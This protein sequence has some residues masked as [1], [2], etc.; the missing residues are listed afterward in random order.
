MNR[1]SNRLEHLFTRQIDGEATGEEREFLNTLLRDDRTARTLFRE[2]R[3]QDRALGDALRQALGRPARP[4]STHY[5]RLRIGRGLAA[6][7]A[8]G[9]A[10][11]IWLQPGQ[12]N[13]NH[14]KQGPLQAA[15]LSQAP[16]GSWFTPL[17][18]AGDTVTP[19]PTA[20]ERPQLRLRG[21][22]RNWIVIPGNRAGQYLIIEVDRVHTHIISV[23]QDF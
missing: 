19:V 15:A 2:Y 5:L 1:G 3:H 12:P 20:Y 16:A 9:L 11:F 4:A 7:A 13:D 23:H 6:V 17:K 22:E 10:A 21:T 8:A 18:P 14:A